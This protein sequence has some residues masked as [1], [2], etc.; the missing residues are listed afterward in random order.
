M[1][2]DEK[3]YR[4]DHCSPEQ[5]NQ[6]LGELCEKAID[7]YSI[8]SRVPSVTLSTFINHEESDGHAWARLETAKQ[9]VI[10]LSN[11]VA[12]LRK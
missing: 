7:L 4:A 2:E 3:Q 11:K 12:P 1:D 8:A 9:Y 5:F 10:G 6:L